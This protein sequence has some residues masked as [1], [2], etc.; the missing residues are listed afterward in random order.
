MMSK[1]FKQFLGKRPSPL[2]ET[3][4]SNIIERQFREKF[5]LLDDT[6]D[7][8]EDLLDENGAL[9]KMMTTDVGFSQDSLAELQ[10][11]KLYAKRLRAKAEET[12]MSGVMSLDNWDPE[13]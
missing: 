12:F 11:L 7:A 1:T 5:A 6:L 2:I 4:S 10:T 3:G 8:L 13:N 9:S